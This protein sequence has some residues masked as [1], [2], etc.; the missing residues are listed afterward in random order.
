MIK[1]EFQTLE[2]FILFLNG[3]RGE[4]L[5]VEKIKKLTTELNKSSKTLE[6]AVKKGV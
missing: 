6:T 5:D 1:L 2:A 3:V 4:P